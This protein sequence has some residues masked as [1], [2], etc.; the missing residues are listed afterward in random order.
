MVSSSSKDRLAAA[1][2]DAVDVGQEEIAALGNEA[3]LVLDVDRHLKVAIPAL[4]FPTVGRQQ[5][6]VAEDPRSVE[7]EP[8]PIEDDDVGAISRKLVESGEPGS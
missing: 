4:A 7:I 2:I 3:D 6:V 5:R 8:E 1:L